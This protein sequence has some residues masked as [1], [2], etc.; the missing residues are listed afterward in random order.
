MRLVLPF[1]S[2]ISFNCKTKYASLVARQAALSDRLCSSLTWELS[3][4]LVLNKPKPV[5][6]LT[7]RQ[8]ILDIPSQLMASKPLFH[9][10]DRTWHSQTG[11]TLTF[12]PEN[13]ANAR[14]FVVG[15][16]PYI[17]VTHSSWFLKFFS[18]DAQLR[19][20]H[21]ICDKETRQAYL[22][23][24]AELDGF[25]AGDDE[26]NMTDSPSLGPAVAV[27]LEHNIQ[28]VANLI[29][30]NFR[31]YTMIRTLFPHS[32]ESLPAAPRHL[33]NPP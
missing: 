33:Y 14:S 30:K 15:L 23:E 12:L 32:I 18:E 2:M 25:L 17:K 7:L 5:S 13:E 22:D 21:S 16:I 9:S 20:L 1:Q 4:N 11:I 24:E 27:D 31:H 19:H 26:F 29:W 6:G 10:V 3:A 8:L 28:R